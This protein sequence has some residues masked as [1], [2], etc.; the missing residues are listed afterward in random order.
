MFKVKYSIQYKLLYGVLGS[1]GPLAGVLLFIWEGFIRNDRDYDIWVKSVLI[2]FSFF[3][4]AVGVF[5]LIR[6]IKEFDNELDIYGD[7]RMVAVVDGKKIKFNISEI[8]SRQYKRNGTI[9]LLTTS[10]DLGK[11]RLDL[12]MENIYLLLDILLAKFE[13]DTF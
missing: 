5:N 7:G 10:V 11:F 3:L 8:E 12:E 9:I 1:L 13:Y 4:L 6:A 2:S